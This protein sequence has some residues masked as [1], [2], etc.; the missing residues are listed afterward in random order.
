MEL[1]YL[2]SGLPDIDALWEEDFEEDDDLLS[3]ESKMMKLLRKWT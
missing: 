2:D 3:I 1:P